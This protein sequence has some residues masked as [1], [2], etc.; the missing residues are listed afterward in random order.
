MGRSRYSRRDIHGPSRA[1]F[2]WPVQIMRGVRDGR[3]GREMDLDNFLD[4]LDAEP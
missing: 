3:A 2:F 1:P 4:Q